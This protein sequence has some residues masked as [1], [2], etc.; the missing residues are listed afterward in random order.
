MRSS[1][2][3]NTIRLRIF[4]L[5]RIFEQRT[6]EDHPLTTPEIR[7]IMMKEHGIYMHR[8]TVYYDVERLKAAGVDIRCIRSS[9]NKYYLE[10]RKFEIAELK[11]L[12]D[13]VESSRFITETQS[14]KLTEKLLT[15]ASESSSEKLK[16]NLHVAGRVKAGNRQ[17]FYIVDAINE[18]I[19]TGRRISFKYFDYDSR[20]KERLRNQGNPYTVS[21]YSLI[22]NGD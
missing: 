9:A 22:W 18:A 4:Y 12:I 10:N 17:I 8:T 19:N 5:Y 20:K 21:Q 14:N 11:L 7:D 3:E 16:R 15:L 1:H 13:A 6:D 2:D